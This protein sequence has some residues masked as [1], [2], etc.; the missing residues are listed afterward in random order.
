[1]TEQ[2]GI[3]P[4]K[5][6]VRK[7]IRRGRGNASGYGGEC[8]RGHKGQKSRTG[9]STRPGFEGG[10]NPLY[11]RLPKKRGQRN[12]FRI[13]Y[14]VINLDVLEAKFN[15]G[16]IVS[17]ETLTEKGLIT[18]NSRVKVLGDG[19]ITKK[20]TVKVDKLSKS[21]REKLTAANATIE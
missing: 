15:D 3:R 1:M 16:E 9:S 11:R 20:L 4:A 19:D 10:Q 2:L 8:G 5:G 18:K 13:E 14:A 6:S 17:N 7:R 12:H 21:A